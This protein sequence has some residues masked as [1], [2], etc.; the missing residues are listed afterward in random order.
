MRVWV[1]GLVLALLAQLITSTA[2][3]PSTSS[4][5]VEIGRPDH[6]DLSPPLRLLAPGK[7][8]TIR[9]RPLQRIHPIGR[10]GLR[11][12]AVQRTATMP[13]GT[14]PGKTFEG[15]GLPIYAVKALPANA[16]GAPGARLP[17]GDG[18]RLD[19]YVQWVNEDLAVFDKGTGQITFGPVPGNTIWSGFGGS[20]ETQ[21]DGS[22]NVL[23]DMHAHRWVLSQFAVSGGPPYYQ[24][25]AVSTTADA[26]GPYRRYAFAYNFLNDHPR[27]SLWPD[28]YYVAFAMFDGGVFRGA[29]LCAYDRAAIFD[30]VPR[31]VTQQCY[32]LAYQHGALLPADWEGTV[33]P[34]PGAPAL[35]LGLGPSELTV[36]AYHV[37]WDN[38]GNTTLQGPAHIP[39]APSSEACPYGPCVPQPRSSEELEAIGDQL[40]PRVVYR[41]LPDWHESLLVNHA[42]MD[43][44]HA[45]GFRWYVLRNA[46]GET[47][48][49]KPP[50]LYQQSTYAP[51]AT[52]RW[53]ASG[54]MDKAANIAFGYSVSSATVYPGLRYTGRTPDDPPHSLRVENVMVEGRGS[55]T[56]PDSRWSDYSSLRIDPTDDCTFWYT[57]QYQKLTGSFSW[58]TRIGSFKYPAC[59]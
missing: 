15:I 52:S 58:S 26:T 23:Y 27:L 35:F 38:P 8:S 59:Q 55:Q 7:P 28:A 57:N 46:E 19:Q 24:C 42:V 53:V 13:L 3:Q 36:W 33:A 11:D 44:N 45:V 31:P 22:P 48:A 43:P 56:P 21:N 10:F 54:T 12:P 2:S 34:P 6:E 9:K 41:V 40:M 17:L 51:D 20:C 37:D 49:S 18:H 30:V 5:P 50:I 25:L 32:Q 14:V 4:R 29:R 39:V 1:V 47:L 16:T